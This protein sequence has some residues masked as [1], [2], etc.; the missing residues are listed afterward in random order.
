MAAATKRDDAIVQKA[1]ATS[2]SVLQLFVSLDLPTKIY[3]KMDALQ[4]AVKKLET[5]DYDLAMAKQS[6]TG[7]T[8]RP[9]SNDKPDDAADKRSKGRGGDNDDDQEDW[10]NNS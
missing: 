5:I 2:L 4:T 8:K 9:I 1:Y 3:K 7:A 10:N 6:K